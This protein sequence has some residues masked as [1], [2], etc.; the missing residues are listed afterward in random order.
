M[1]A[2]WGPDSHL[3]E[4]RLSESGERAS[5]GLRGPWVWTPA[6]AGTQSWGGR[7]KGRELDCTC[8]PLPGWGG[9]GGGVNVA[10]G[11]GRSLPHPVRREG[12]PGGSAGW[13]A[14]RKP[15]G[16]QLPHTPNSKFRTRA[17]L[18]ALTWLCTQQ[19]DMNESLTRYGLL[20][21]LGQAT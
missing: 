16:S 8:G 4:K 20:H 21:E 5:Q 1:W 14:G 9:D 17:W 6:P 18:R 13:S 7:G 2:L 11:R 15:P 12:A 3:R 19:P 10:A